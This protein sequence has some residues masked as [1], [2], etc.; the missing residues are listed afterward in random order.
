MGKSFGRATSLPRSCRGRR[1][2]DVSFP[3]RRSICGPTPY[4][5]RH[6]QDDGEHESNHEGQDERGVHDQG[7]EVHI[8]SIFACISDDHRRGRHDQRDRKNHGD[9]DVE[10]TQSHEGTDGRNQAEPVLEADDDGQAPGMLFL[11]Q[12]LRLEEQAQSEDRH[13]LGACRALLNHIPEHLGE[14]IRGHTE[15]T[16]RNRCG[17]RH[18][19]RHLR[20]IDDNLG[21]QHRHP[22]RDPAA[23]RRLALFRGGEAQRYICRVH[24]GL[25]TT[26][27]RRYTGLQVPGLAAPGVRCARWAA[28]GCRGGRL[29]ALGVRRAW[30]FVGRGLGLLAHILEANQVAR[31]MATQHRVQRRADRVSRSGAD[32]NVLDVRHGGSAIHLLGLRR[33]FASRIEGGNEVGGDV[34]HHNAGHIPSRAQW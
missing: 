13:D 20:D 29:A 32:Q 4:L 31:P 19:D 16:H 5:A 24:R 1:S 23:I 15:T 8:M 10:A 28:R 27:G 17:K 2:H 18:G 9:H 12:K 25:P 11:Q 22:R 34:S 7:G 6:G 14:V 26:L 3:R 33:R 21:Q 30:G